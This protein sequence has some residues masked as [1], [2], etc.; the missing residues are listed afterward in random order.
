MKKAKMLLSCAIMLMF[1][2]SIFAGQCPEKDLDCMA[3][4]QDEQCCDKNEMFFMCNE[5]MAKEKCPMF[6]CHMKRCFMKNF[7][8]NNSR[9]FK[10]GCCEKM[11]KKLNL[12]DK[13]KEDLKTLKETT[14][15]KQQEL[16]KTIMNEKK[17]ISEELLKEKYS[18][19]VIKKSVKNI[20]DAS[21]KIIDNKIANKQ[22]LKKILTNEQY[23]KMFKPKTRC[24]M[25]AER[26]NLSEEQKEKVATI[27]EN[28][29][30][31]TKEF[32]DKKIEKKKLLMEELKKED[33]NND[34]V[35]Q[36]M[37]DISDVSN[38]LFKLKIGTKMELKSVLSFEQYNKM[39]NFHKRCE[40][41]PVSV[42]EME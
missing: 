6:N 22:A 30:K 14:I 5:N 25:L 41:A 21:N 10:R 34:T 8:G 42:E 37:Q 35:S 13:Q 27:M 17:A 32:M 18:E 16:M 1:S 29:D 20:K 15:K 3:P 26:L 33:C 38:E 4:M 31:E 12:T 11:F 36:L 19:K 9:H 2:V 40:V 28:S 23:I 7:C 39:N 24:D